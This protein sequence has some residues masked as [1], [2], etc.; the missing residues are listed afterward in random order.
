M[1]YCT[2]HAYT[3]TLPS[4]CRC[5]ECLVWT[6]VASTVG[7]PPGHATCKMNMA[8]SA[9]Q[10]GPTAR[11]STRSHL[12]GSA[13]LLCCSGTTWAQ[14]HLSQRRLCA[15]HARHGGCTQTGGLQADVQQLVADLG[16]VQGLDG[17]HSRCVL[18]KVLQDT[19]MRISRNN[20]VGSV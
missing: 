6:S 14:D 5:P 8:T 3:Y 12:V 16:A 2:H 1:V 9:S 19:T 15:L 11:R 10:V 20:D 7:T 18:S 4:L 17:P 13:C